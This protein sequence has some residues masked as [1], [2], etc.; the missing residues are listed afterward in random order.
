M[1]TKRGHA[2]IQSM[3]GARA[4]ALDRQLRTQH[5]A[6]DHSLEVAVLYINTEVS[7]HENADNKT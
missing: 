4:A 7:F 5:L 3:G 2:H 6:R 1:R